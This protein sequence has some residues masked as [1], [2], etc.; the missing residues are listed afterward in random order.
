MCTIKFT[1]ERET[2]NAIRFTEILEGNMNNPV[3]GSVYFQ[4]EALKAK[5]W[6]EGKCITLTVDIVD[7]TPAEGSTT[8]AAKNEENIRKYKE[9]QAAKKAA[10]KAPAKKAPAKKAPAKVE[11][12]QEAKAPAKT[13]KKA[14][15]KTAKKAPARKRTKKA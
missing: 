5:G 4:K 6:V 9:A 2:K 8:A 15:A 3:M 12:K 1:P 10:K 13:A 14:P 11:P 7:E